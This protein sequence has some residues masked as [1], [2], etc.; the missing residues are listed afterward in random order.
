MTPTQ[1]IAEA[2]SNY[3][4]LVEKYHKVLEE[5]KTETWARIALYPVNL[6]TYEMGD[7]NLL[8]IVYKDWTYCPTDEGITLKMGKIAL[9]A[10]EVAK[11]EVPQELKGQAALQERMRIM[12]ADDKLSWRYRHCREALRNLK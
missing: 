9:T 12:S 5:L 7:K 3:N 6:N 4:A 2:I 10:C 11:M 1:M 8:G